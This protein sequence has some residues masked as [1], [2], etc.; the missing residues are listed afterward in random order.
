MPDTNLQMPN[1]NI[2]PLPDLSHLSRAY[3]QQVNVVEKD[4]PFNQLVILG[5]GFDLAC[6]LKS[7]YKHFF[8]Y[9]FDK[10]ELGSNYWYHIFRNFHDN[11][12]I[13][14]GWTDIEKQILIELKNIEKLY[15]IGILKENEY[16]VQ[17]QLNEFLY[18]SNSN[19]SLSLTTSVIKSLYS[20]Y[21]R[22]PSKKSFQEQLI[23]KLLLLEDDFC[24]Y[25]IEQI[26]IEDEQ[27]NVFFSETK[28]EDL[29]N[30]YIKSLIIGYYILTSELPDFSTQHLQ[31][32][33]RDITKYD[34]FDLFFKEVDT[35]NNLFFEDDIMNSILSF[36]YTE[37]LKK[38]NL[39]NIH[40]AL[41]EGNIL[42]GIDYDK[43]KDNFTEP[44][45]EFSKSYR[46]LESGRDTRMNISSDIDIIKFYGHGLGEA[47]YSY[48]QAIFDSVDLYHSNTKII[49]YW[50]Q[51][52]GADKKTI[53][54]EQVKNITNLI[55]EYGTTFTNQDHGRNLLTKLQLENRLQII[56][57]PISNLFKCLV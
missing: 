49:F 16:I 47:D 3:T 43:L 55:E 23:N 19:S 15:S 29:N 17:E 33:L 50:S 12:T 34:S 54:I 41:S 42:F 44:P 40:G 22:L 57:I 7:T 51:Y 30:Y 5:N 56:E 36:N 10:E 32:I 52:E 45:I 48:F 28:N 2:P 21:H 8:V 6:G 37:P 31:T 20:Y 1:F 38:L 24:K 26:N 53:R 39:R 25:L 4:K 46:I 27:I 18:S 9:I 13:L 14:N 35:I 11:Q